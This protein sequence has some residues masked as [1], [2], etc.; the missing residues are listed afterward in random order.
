MSFDEGSQQMILPIVYFLN[1]F[2]ELD[3]FLRK[4]FKICWIIEK[5]VLVIV[6]ETIFKHI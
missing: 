5:V 3:N 4:S 1:S 6:S 2:F